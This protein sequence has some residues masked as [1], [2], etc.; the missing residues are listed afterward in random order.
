MNT[1]PDRRR[2]RRTVARALAVVSYPAVVLLAAA[3]LVGRAACAAAAVGWE[4]FVRRVGPAGRTT[5]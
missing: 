3:V 4:E 1:A 5:R 2:P